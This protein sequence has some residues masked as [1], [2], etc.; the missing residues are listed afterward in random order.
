M[1]LFIDDQK[2]L[3]KLVDCKELVD[4]TISGT[5]LGDGGNKIFNINREIAFVNSKEEPIKDENGN[6]IYNMKFKN[7]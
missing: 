2:V 4:N 3:W 1:R 7:N 6:Y 5:I